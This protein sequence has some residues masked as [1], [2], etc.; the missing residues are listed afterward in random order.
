M[1]G[2]PEHRNIDT[3]PYLSAMNLVVQS[4]ASKHGVRVGRNKYFFPSP[5]EHYVLSLGVEAHRGFFMSIR[6]MYKQL[7]VNINV[8]MTAFYTP[9]NLAQAMMAFQQ[10]SQNG[11]PQAFAN[12]LKVATRHLGYT[13]KSTIFKIMTS[14]TA[15]TARFDCE[16]FGRKVTVEEFFKLSEYSPTSGL[17]IDSYQLF[18]STR[19]RCGTR[20]TS[21]SST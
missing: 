14:L 18:K 15:R 17:P 9:G 21:P 4:Y 16:E 12:R 20:R 1:D 6:P 5:T 13:K 19:S 10:Q 7:M 11:M 8:C 2:R 3:Q